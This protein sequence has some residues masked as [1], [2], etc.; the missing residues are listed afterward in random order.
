M[1]DAAEAGVA[2]QKNQQK[3]STT[4]SHS[5]PGLQYCMLGETKVHYKFVY[6]LCRA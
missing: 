6:L 1:N 5:R 3:I 4:A 2:A